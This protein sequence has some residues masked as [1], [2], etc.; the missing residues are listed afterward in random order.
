MGRMRSEDFNLLM[1][2]IQKLYVFGTYLKCKT[3]KT[4]REILL[5]HQLLWL[6]TE[7]FFKA[8]NYFVYEQDIHCTNSEVQTFQNLDR[9]NRL[10]SIKYYDHLIDNLVKCTMEINT[11]PYSVKHFINSHAKRSS[12]IIFKNRKHLKPI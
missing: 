9:N 4:R 10:N 7:V 8:K 6:S 2:A 12:Y 11:L 3:D 5:Q 1:I